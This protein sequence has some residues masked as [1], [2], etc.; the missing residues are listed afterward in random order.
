MSHGIDMEYTPGVNILFVPS[1]DR[2]ILWSCSW[3]A[4]NGISWVCV[5]LLGSTLGSWINEGT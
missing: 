5:T 4:A 2:D 3:L 1:P